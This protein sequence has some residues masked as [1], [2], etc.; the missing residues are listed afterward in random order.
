VNQKSRMN[1]RGGSRGL[2]FGSDICTPPCRT[3]SR[4]GRERPRSSTRRG[5]SRGFGAS[6]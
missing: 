1:Q 3:A 6:S 5:N 4:R 2:A